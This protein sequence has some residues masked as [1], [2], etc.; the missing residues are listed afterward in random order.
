MKIFLYSFL[1]VLCQGHLMAQGD[2]YSSERGKVSFISEAPLETIKAESDALRGVIRP[3]SKSFAFSINIS[4]FE[5]FNS[6]IQRVHF[7][8][9]YMEQKKY[10]TAHFSGKLI[11]DIPFDVP[12]TYTV[13][14]KGEFDIHGIKKERIIKGTL[15]ITKDAAQISTTFS[16]PLADHGIEIPRIVKQKIAEQI[17]VNIDIAFVQGSKS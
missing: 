13:R 17:T 6:D 9:N 12:G 10:P 8:E 3:A 16:V 14:A 11:E 2:M 7:M 5:G 4:T 1:I 15:T